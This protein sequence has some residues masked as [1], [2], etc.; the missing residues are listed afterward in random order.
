MGGDVIK[1][2]AMHDEVATGGRI[3]QVLVDDAQPGQLEWQ[4]AVEDVIVVAAHVDHLG[5]LLLHLLQQRADEMRVL[6]PPAAGGSQSPRIDDVAIQDDLIAHAVAQKVS[7]LD[8]LGIRHAEVDVGH[9]ERL[10]A[11]L[12]FHAWQC[13]HDRLCHINA[14]PQ[15]VE[16][17]VFVT[18]G[19]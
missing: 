18:D 6:M 9:D 4:K 11:K 12:G 14:C 7:G 10:D 8:R 19:P 17:N 15:Q 13:C 16:R 1:T 2:V 3:V 5:A